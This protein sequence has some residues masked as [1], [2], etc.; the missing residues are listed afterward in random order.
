MGTKSQVWGSGSYSQSSS[1]SLN[2]KLANLSKIWDWSS[3]R[4]CEEIEP[5]LKSPRH[6]DS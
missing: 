2:E 4:W 1:I 3:S 6:H 5:L